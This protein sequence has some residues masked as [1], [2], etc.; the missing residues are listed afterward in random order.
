MA[1]EMQQVEQAL[2]ALA[3]AARAAVIH[4]GLR[5]LEPGPT[6]QDRELSAEWRDEVDRRVSDLLAGGEQVTEALAYVDQLR[7][8]LPMR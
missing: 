3:P 7:N 8:A 5:S 6:V 1:Q 2:L 4:A